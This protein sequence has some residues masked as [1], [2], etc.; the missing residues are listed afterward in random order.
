MQLERDKIKGGNAK[1]EMK[2]PICSQY[3]KKR[4]M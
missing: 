2:K 3:N 1:Q 4:S